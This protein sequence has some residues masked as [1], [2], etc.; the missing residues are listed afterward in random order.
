MRAEVTD[1]PCKQCGAQV[2]EPC[3]SP[4]EAKRRLGHASR[5]DKMIR[6]RLEAES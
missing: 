1:F 5:Q 3:R 6:A 2:G 4:A